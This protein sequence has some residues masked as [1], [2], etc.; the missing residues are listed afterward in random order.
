MAPGSRV[1]AR[2]LG[3]ELTMFCRIVLDHVYL[4]L[5]ASYI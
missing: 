4:P 2:I 1:A 5:F 3:E